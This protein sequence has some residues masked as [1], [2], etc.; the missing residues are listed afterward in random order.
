VRKPSAQGRQEVPEFVDDPRRARIPAGTQPRAQE[1]AGAAFEPDERVIHVLVVPPMKE[2]ELLRPM[3][4]VIRAVEIEDEI[5][6][7]LVGSVG[8][9]AEPVNASAREALDRGPVDRILQPRERRLRSECREAIGRDHLERRIMPQPIGVV[10]I[11]VSG[12]DLI[13]PLTD[14]RVEIVRNVARV[15]SVGNPADHVGA[16]PELLVEFSDEQQAGIRREGAAGKIDD[17]FG[18]ESEAKL[19]ITLCSH[20]TSDV[21]RPSRPRTPRKYHDFF[22]GDGV[23]TYSFVNY[24]G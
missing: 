20:R 23:F 17:K 21:A 13:Q 4:R 14:E 15:P 5:R 9:G 7:V 8:I 18:L 6:G 11:F 2:R 3:R 22:E 1:Q 24:P 10:D 16:E 19:A 12:D